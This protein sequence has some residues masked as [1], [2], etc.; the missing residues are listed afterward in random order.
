MRD[1]RPFLVAVLLAVPAACHDDRE[2][3]HPGVPPGSAGLDVGPPAP[4]T[5]NEPV[6]PGLPNAREPDRVLAPG[7]IARADSSGPNSGASIAQATGGVGGT[8]G[9]GGTS[10]GGLGAGGGIGGITNTGG[11]IVRR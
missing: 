3:E 9:T 8:V 5:T 6:V 1:L 4:A 10:M 11:S 7:P 2:P